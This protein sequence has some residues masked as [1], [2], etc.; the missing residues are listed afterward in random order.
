MNLNNNEFS[1]DSDYSKSIARGTFIETSIEPGFFLMTFQND[2][3][4]P[5][6]LEKDID[7]SY[8]Q[9]HFCL[10]GG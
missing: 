2:F 1:S 6:L 9:F 8:I 7:S 3:E 4:A 10:K 5:K